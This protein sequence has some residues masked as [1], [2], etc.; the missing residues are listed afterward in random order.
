MLCA[1]G[2]S[3]ELTKWDDETFVDCYGDEVEWQREQVEDCR[4]A[5]DGVW[6]HDAAYDKWQHPAVKSSTSRIVSTDGEGQLVV[7]DSLEAANERAAAVFQ[8]MLVSCGPPMRHAFV[9]NACLQRLL[10]FV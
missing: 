4:K 9:C 6:F 7:F 8:D 2:G 3:Q 5:G 10:A 1:A